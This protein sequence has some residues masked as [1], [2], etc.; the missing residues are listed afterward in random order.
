[1]DRARW[2]WR[3]D[4]LL[5]GD[6]SLSVE[7]AGIDEDHLMRAWT[8]REDAAVFVAWFAEK[9]DLIR[10]EPNPFRPTARG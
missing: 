10:F 9:Y 8:H 2:V 1:M 4:Q 7:D 5:R 6:W 3:V